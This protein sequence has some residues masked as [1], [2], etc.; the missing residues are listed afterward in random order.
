MKINNGDEGDPIKGIS[1]CYHV[2]HP[3]IDITY[4]ELQ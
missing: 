1:S 4:S 2:S 3:L